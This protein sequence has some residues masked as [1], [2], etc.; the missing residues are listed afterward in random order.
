MAKLLGWYH[1]FLVQQIMGLGVAINNVLRT[2]VE[3]VTHLETL[4]GDDRIRAE[5]DRIEPDLDDD[6]WRAA[7]VEAARG[8]SGPRR[9]R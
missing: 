5:L 4:V 2:L 3:K 8:I 1:Q 6:L 9:A 7:V